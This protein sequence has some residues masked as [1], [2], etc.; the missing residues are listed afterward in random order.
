[1]KLSW[2]T[3]PFK[4]AFLFLLIFV[5]WQAYLFLRPSPRE[6][7]AE[8]LKAVEMV[9]SRVVSEISP[10]IPATAVFGVAGFANDP[11]AAF[12]DRMSRAISESYEWR[13][14]DNSPIRKFLLDISD[15]LARAVSLDEVFRV[16]RG[17][18]LDVLV[19]GEVIAVER[20]GEG[21]R[22]EAAVYVYRVSDGEWVFR[23]EV[24]ETWQP[25]WAEEY[26][27]RPRARYPLLRF[28]V[29]AAF[30]LLLPFATS[31]AVHRALEQRTNLASFALIAV[32]TALNLL[33][34]L[35]L[36]GFR[37]LG[38]AGGLLFIVAFLLC[39]AYNYWACE[40]IAGSQ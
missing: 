12:T 37:I 31:F 20:E 33:A 35:V 38:T 7:S 8:E 23:Q 22:A 19:G 34:A 39:A 1:M 10:E 17:A 3:L 15:T 25:G 2:F 27:V 32:Y 40:K 4:L 24:S 6:Y 5:I 21:G 36:S 11:T 30:V 14:E 28:L 16:G 18:G 9:C 13:V 26:P 29:W